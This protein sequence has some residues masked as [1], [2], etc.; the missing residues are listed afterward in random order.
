MSRFAEPL[1]PDLANVSGSS[2][3]ILFLDDDPNRAEV[4]LVQNPDA[5]WV[6]TV[7][8]CLERLDEEWDEVHLDHDL[9]GETFVDF[10]RSDCGMEIVRWLCLAP[11]PHLQATQFY[12]HSHNPNAANMMSL[13]LEVTGFRVETR[14][15]GSPPPL[16]INVP[17]RPSLLRRLLMW[18]HGLLSR[19]TGR[20]AR[21]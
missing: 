12:V 1:R 18:L 10:E 9:G 5:V 11:R 3:R 15:F 2:R 19:F 20:P 6:R 14:P 7:E 4:F 8:E 17:D 13:H 21:S 16:P